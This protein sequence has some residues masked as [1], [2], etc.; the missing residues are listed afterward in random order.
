MGFF[1]LHGAIEFKLG[2]LTFRRLGACNRAEGLLN[3]RSVYVSGVQ[4]SGV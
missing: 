1:F 2:C 3:D 4:I